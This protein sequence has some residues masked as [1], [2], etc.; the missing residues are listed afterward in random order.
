VRGRRLTTETDCNEA[1]IRADVYSFVATKFYAIVKN[2]ESIFR[3]G[4]EEMVYL[5]GVRYYGFVDEDKLLL[6]YPEDGGGNLLLNVTNYHYPQ[7]RC[8]RE[9]P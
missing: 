8:E 5:W 4:I 2:S 1:L 6:D 7:C 9:S 3:H